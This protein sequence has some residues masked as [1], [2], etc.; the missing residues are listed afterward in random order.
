VQQATWNNFQAMLAGDMT[1]E[2]AL[3]AVDGVYESVIQ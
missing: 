3:Q 1:P 2:G